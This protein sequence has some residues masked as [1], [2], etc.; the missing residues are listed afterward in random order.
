MAYICQECKSENL[1]RETSP[2]HCMECG[3]IYKTTKP[4]VDRT[5]LF[6]P[7]LNSETVSYED[8]CKTPNMIERRISK[9]IASEMDRMVDAGI[10]V[11]DDA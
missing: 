1:K 8:S 3:W 10:L 6:G 4:S 5:I 11:R 7:L 9:T 2:I